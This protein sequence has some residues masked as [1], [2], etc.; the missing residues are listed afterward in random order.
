MKGSQE[1][2]LPL[3]RPSLYTF[4]GQPRFGMELLLL[5]SQSFLP[6][7]CRFG[8]LALLADHFTS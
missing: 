3:T 7:A 8:S 4:D 1:E 6:L 5:I 2:K